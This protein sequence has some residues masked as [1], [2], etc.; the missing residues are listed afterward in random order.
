MVILVSIHLASWL[1]AFDHALD[2][3]IRP[4]TSAKLELQILPVLKTHVA[5]PLQPNT[6]CFSNEPSAQMTLKIFFFFINLSWEEV[7]G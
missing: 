7:L 6:K 2:R 5:V 3:Q 4:L 1:I